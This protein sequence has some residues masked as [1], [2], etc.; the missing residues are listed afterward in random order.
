MQQNIKNALLAVKYLESQHLKCAENLELR[1]NTWDDD[2]PK[3][4]VLALI[5]NHKQY[6]KNLLDVRLLLTNKKRK[7]EPTKSH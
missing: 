6:A 7:N 2:M 5:S 4:L 1:I 3:K